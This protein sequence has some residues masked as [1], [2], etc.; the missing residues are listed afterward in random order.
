MIQERIE[1]IESKIQSSPHVPE[2]TKRELLLLLG[3]LRTE[4]GELA[5]TH[6]E[7]AQR[8]AQFTGVTADE[9]IREETRPEVMQPAV[10]GLTSSVEELETSHPKITAAVNRLAVILSNMGI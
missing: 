2:E 6:P 1:Q 10:Q 4:A 5:A 8:L 3:T 9:A 7:N